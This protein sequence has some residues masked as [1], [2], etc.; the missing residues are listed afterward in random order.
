MYREHED[1]ID[2]FE[3]ALRYYDTLPT[4]QWLSAESICPSNSTAYSLTDLQ[5]A[6]SAGF[7][8]VPYIGC[9][10]PAYNTTTAGQGTLDSGKVN[11]S[12]VWYYHHVLGRVQNGQAM[13]VSASIDGG[14]ISNCATTPGALNYLERSTGSEA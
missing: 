14:S 12:E 4:Y 8:E 6:L 2:F 5:S 10:G 13:P 11:L 1:V 3:T 7:G 9:S